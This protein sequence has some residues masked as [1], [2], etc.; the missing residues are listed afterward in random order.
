MKTENTKLTSLAPPTCNVRGPKR[1]AP[2]ITVG[3]NL[4]GPCCNLWHWW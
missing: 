4:W 2:I 3:V 1:N